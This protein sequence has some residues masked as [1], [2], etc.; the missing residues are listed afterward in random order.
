MYDQHYDRREPD[1]IAI[2]RVLPQM[3]PGDETNE[4]DPFRYGK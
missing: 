4:S 1:T 2:A 3:K